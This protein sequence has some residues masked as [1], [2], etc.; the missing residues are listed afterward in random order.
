MNRKNKNKRTGRI[1]YNIF[2]GI[3]YVKLIF[4]WN[5]SIPIY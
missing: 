1:K 5:V 3:K 2:N 4:D